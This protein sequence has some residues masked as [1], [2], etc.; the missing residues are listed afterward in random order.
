MKIQFNTYRIQEAYVW[1]HSV[2][3]PGINYS[4][5]MS[6][7]GNPPFPSE[8]VDTIKTA[9]DIERHF[10]DYCERAKTCGEPVE[11]SWF[12]PSNDR[13]RA[14][15]GFTKIKESRTRKQF[16]TDAIDAAA[17]AKFKETQPA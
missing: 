3:G 12:R 5:V 11:V 2:L 1:D 16:N 13:S 17:W 4:I 10:A 6:M 7:G 9:D 15:P 8:T 14:F